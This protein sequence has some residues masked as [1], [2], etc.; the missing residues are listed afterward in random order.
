MSETNSTPQYVDYTL[1]LLNTHQGLEGSWNEVTAQIPLSWYL[2]REVH[3]EFLGKIS[4][5]TCGR[6]IKKTYGDG[7][8]Y[9]CFIDAPSAAECVLRPALCLA[10]KGQGRDLEWELRNHAQP[11]L[12][13]LALSS[14]YKVGVTRDW[15]TRWVD[16]GAAA[17]QVIAETPYRQLAGQIEVFLSQHYSDRTS[18]QRML[19]GEVLE[20]ADLETEVLRAR[21]LL[22]PELNIYS[23]VEHPS[24][25]INY[26]VLESIN[27]VK[28]IK[29]AKVSSHQ[30]RLIGARGQYLIFEGGTVINL[31]AHTGYHVKISALN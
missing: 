3:I 29:L 7:Y 25:Y 18:W 22:P 28:S 27:R 11:H 30:A 23:E 2:D 14:K 6:S 20:G 15:P 1:R 17:I 16:Q 21:A 5:V 4:C 24:L 12:V 26:P 19:K 8:C 9:P 10:H 31:R 13:Y